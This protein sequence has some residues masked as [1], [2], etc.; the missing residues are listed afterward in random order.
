MSRSFKIGPL[1]VLLLDKNQSIPSSNSLNPDTVAIKVSPSIIDSAFPVCFI[2]EYLSFGSHH[3]LYSLLHPVSSVHYHHKRHHL[4]YDR[5]PHPN[6]L[7]PPS[8]THDPEMT[9]KTQELANRCEHVTKLGVY[10]NIGLVAL[11]GSAGLMTN[12][13]ALIA[14]ATHSLTDLVSDFMTFAT[15]K[16]SQMAPT[17]KFP[18]GFGKIDTLGTITVAGLLCIG[19]YHIVTVSVSQ[20]YAA[21]LGAPTS[22][23]VMPQMA[24]LCAVFSLALKEWLYRITTKAGKE[25]NSSVTVANAW[26][27]RSDA[28]SSGIALLGVGGYY[29]GYPIADPMCGLAVGVYLL[30]IGINIFKLGFQQLLDRNS[31]MHWDM[32]RGIVERCEGV[33]GVHDLVVTQSGQYVHIMCEVMV[34]QQL[35]MKKVSEIVENVKLKLRDTDTLNIQHLGIVPIPSHHHHHHVHHHGDEQKE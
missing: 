33:E 35:T 3:C 2:L 13:M 1:D 32:V 14:D 28:Y 17:S 15:I 22:V 34:D 25:Y 11:K 21:Y 7:S 16:Y 29:V 31:E 10:A 4:T 19:S 23:L 24:M 26:H 30:K 5:H 6:P 20:L 9:S 12:S 27:H 18:L 8:A